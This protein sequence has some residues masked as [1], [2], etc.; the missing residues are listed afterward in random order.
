MDLDE[1]SKEFKHTFFS[2][3]LQ[4]QSQQFEVLESLWPE[5]EDPQVMEQA[6]TIQEKIKQM[7][8]CLEVDYIQ[9]VLDDKVEAFRF[10]LNTAKKFEL[11][12]ATLEK[13]HNFAEV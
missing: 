10:Y 1:T 7:E 13:L 6:K 11:D 4:A 2:A 12:E 9:K 5:S 8:A 3:L